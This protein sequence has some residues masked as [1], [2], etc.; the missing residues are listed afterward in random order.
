MNS[1]NNST[2]ENKAG[3]AILASGIACTIFGL[4]VVGSEISPIVKTSLEWIKAV[5]P[6]SGKVGLTVFVWL[7]LWYSFNVLLSRKPPMGKKLYQIGLIFIVLGYI[8]TFPPFFRLF[9]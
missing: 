7:L 1:I 5:G 8:L 2:Q 6:L 9:V 4:T 3:A